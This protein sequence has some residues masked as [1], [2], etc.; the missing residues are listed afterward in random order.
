MIE[1]GTATEAEM[2]SA[3]LQAEIDSAGR[4]APSLN[5]ALAYYGAPAS[6]VR[7]PDLASQAENLIRSGVLG[8]YRGYPDKLLF[9]GFP[10][11]VTWT[12]VR[13]DSADFARLYCAD[14]HDKLTR[15]SVPDRLILSAARNYSAGHPAAADF[16]HIGAIVADLRTG[17]CFAPLI[18]VEYPNSWLVLIEG[19][20][21][22]IAR[23]I[24][25][26]T[27]DVDLLLGRA[28]SFDTWYFR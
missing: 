3:F 1:L 21:R 8:L 10:P 7:N 13:I 24:A 14:D 6:I 25:K 27:D 9:T 2:V 28:M 17:K 26:M 22:A 18:P 11:D 20:S 23:A 4:F 12:R 19:H 5:N 15:L 16:P